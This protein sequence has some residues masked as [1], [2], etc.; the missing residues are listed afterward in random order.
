MAMHKFGTPLPTW[1]NHVHGGGCNC[2]YSLH[3]QH[4][5]NITINLF[6]DT[7]QWGSCI[8]EIDEEKEEE[9]WAKHH[10]VQ[11]E[12]IESPNLTTG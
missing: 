9:K 10:H 2:C 1:H 12:L 8:G 11:L 3:Q 5:K 7:E 6:M 4:L